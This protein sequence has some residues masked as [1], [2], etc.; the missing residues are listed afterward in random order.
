MIRWGLRLATVGTAIALSAPVVA[1]KVAA[2]Q[3]QSLYEKIAACPAM[4]GAVN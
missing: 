2:G 4:A 3:G 1:D